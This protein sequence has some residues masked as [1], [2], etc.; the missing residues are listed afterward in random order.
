MFASDSA[1]IVSVLM[2][3]VAARK[4]PKYGKELNKNVSTPYTISERVR[5]RTG[6]LLF[7]AVH[8]RCCLHP[9]SMRDGWVHSGI[10]PHTLSILR[11]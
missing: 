2:Y 10:F 6:L 3:Y 5:L 8:P 1:I 11:R 4:S 7:L 9:T